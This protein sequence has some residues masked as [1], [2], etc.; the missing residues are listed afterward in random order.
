MVYGSYPFFLSEPHTS[1]CFA[2]E[3]TN[4]EEN[5]ASIFNYKTIQRTKARSSLKSTLEMKEEKPNQ[6]S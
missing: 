3:E 1:E 6:F 2:G 4:G 5:H